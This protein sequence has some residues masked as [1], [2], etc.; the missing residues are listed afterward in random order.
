MSVAERSRPAPASQIAVRRLERRSKADERD[1][2]SATQWE[3]ILDA[4]ARVF[5]QVGYPSANLDDIAAEVG[6]NRSSIYYYVGN[7]AELLYELGWRTINES[8][9]ALNEMS[10]FGLGPV[11]MVQ[12][13]IRQQMELLQSSYP[14]LFVFHNERRQHIEPELNQLID[15]AAEM[16]ISLM[17]SAIEEGAAAGVFRP[18]LVPRTTARLIIGMC[19]ETRFWWKPDGPK[20]LVEIGDGIAQLVL[21]GLRT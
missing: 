16:R 20:S 13:L 2:A 14:R 8:L 17:A 9:T 19:A 12:A 21:S 1:S 10:E 15:D 11:E 4:A 18:H 7:K 5:H 3:A 6:L